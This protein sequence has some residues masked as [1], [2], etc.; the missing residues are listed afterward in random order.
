MICKIGT[1]FKIISAFQN[2]FFSVYLIF[3]V[4]FIMI[5]ILFPFSLRYQLLFERE[6]GDNLD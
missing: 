4:E 2:D 3:I 5:R 1:C 6:A